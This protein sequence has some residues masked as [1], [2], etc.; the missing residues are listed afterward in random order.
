M[1]LIYLAAT[2]LVKNCLH[3]GY[4]ETI[5]HWSTGPLQNITKITNFVLA[6]FYLACISL[7]LNTHRIHSSQLSITLKAHLLIDASDGRQI[8]CSLGLLR[9]EFVNTPLQDDWNSFNSGFILDWEQNYFPG[10]V[11]GAKLTPPA[12][13]DA[14]DMNYGNLVSPVYLVTCEC[15]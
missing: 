8:Y 10:C 7:A 3:M 1:V 12:Q 6:K 14:K 15:L 13:N 2:L 4:M 11:L 5:G 9:D